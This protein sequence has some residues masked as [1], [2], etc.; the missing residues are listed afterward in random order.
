MHERVIENLERTVEA[1][2]H[3]NQFLGP[4]RSYNAYLQN[5]MMRRAIAKELDII[6]ITIKKILELEPAMPLTNARKIV[7]ARNFLTHEYHRVDEIQV[8]AMI[9]KHLP[10]LKIEI[11]AILAEETGA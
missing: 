4:Q 8:W 3:I 11:E 9:N 7:D 10:I 5:L 2:N 1:I 6:G